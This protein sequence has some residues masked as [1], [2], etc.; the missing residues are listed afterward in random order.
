MNIGGHVK[1]AGWRKREFTRTEIIAADI[2]AE[3]EAALEQFATIAGGCDNPT[4][5]SP[6]QASGVQGNSSMEVTFERAICNR[7]YEVPYGTLFFLVGQ[8]EP[9][10][11]SSSRA[12][13]ALRSTLLTGRASPHLIDSQ[14]FALGE[15]LAHSHFSW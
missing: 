12:V 2:K 15:V 10:T 11:A 5:Q 1:T 13:Q 9:S 3:L 14:L 4:R 6:D 7:C 8:R